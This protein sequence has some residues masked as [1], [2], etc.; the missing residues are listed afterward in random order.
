MY[1]VVSYSAGMMA[2]AARV[3]PD[4]GALLKIRTF[5][6]YIVDVVENIACTYMKYVEEW[7][8]PHSHTV[9]CSMIAVVCGLPQLEFT[10]YFLIA[11]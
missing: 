3:R 4:S 7:K 2:R 1:S 8:Q 6:L 9:C 5:D 10:K 11:C